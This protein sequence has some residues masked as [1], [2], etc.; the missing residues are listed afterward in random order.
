M[1]IIPPKKIPGLEAALPPLPHLPLEVWIIISE[2]GDFTASTLFAMSG[3][4]R[5]WYHLAHAL[6]RFLP[7]DKRSVG[8]GAEKLL[9]WLRDGTLHTWEFHTQLVAKVPTDHLIEK[10]FQTSFTAFCGIKPR[11]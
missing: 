5:A 7:S 6:A 3:T 4:C 9:G 8:V 2:H 10:Q 1:S 11:P